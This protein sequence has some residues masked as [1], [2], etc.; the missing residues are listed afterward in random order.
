MAT[1]ATQLARLRTELAALRARANSLET[2]IDDVRA[3]ARALAQGGDREGA[4]TFRAILENLLDEQG[5]VFQQIININAQIE[6]LSQQQNPPPEPPP[7]QSASQQVETQTN[8]APQPLP[9]ANRPVDAADT[10][11]TAPV[12][13]LE[14]TQAITTAS[15]N[16]VAL[17]PPSS[18]ASAEGTAGEAEA[19]AAVLAAGQ[20]AKDDARN[21]AP[22]TAAVN[23]TET[24]EPN[25][26]PRPNILDEFASYTY[27]ASVYLLSTEQYVQLLSSNNKRVDGYNLLF[28]SAG[29]AN[30]RGGPK[31]AGEAS[32]AAPAAADAGRNP[33]FDNDF[34]I[35]SITVETLPLGKGT[36][37]VHNAS[38]LKF[39]LVE[40]NGI[41]LLDRL[42]DA[43][44]NFEPRD[45]TGRVNYTAVTYLMVIR[46]YGYDSMGQAVQVRSRQYDAEGA[47]DPQAVIEKF[48]PFRVNAINWSVGSRLVTY[49]WECTPIGQQIAGYTAR[50]TVP[51]DVQ[52]T[53]TT[54]GKLLSGTTAFSN[55]NAPAANPGASTTA[56]AG[57][58]QERAGTSTPAPTTL[59]APAKAIAAPSDKR[60]LVQGLADALNQFQQ[61]LVKR[62][63]YT[64][65]DVYEIEFAGPGSE[66]IR[67]AVLASA[68]QNPIAQTAAG[69]AATQDP[70][71]LRPATNSVDKTTKN[72]SITAGQQILQVIDL[73]IRNSSYVYDQSLVIVEKD[74]TV[75]P[76]PNARNQSVRWYTITMQAERISKELDPKRNDYAYRIKYVISPFVVKNLDSVYFPRP[77][78][79]GVHKSYPYWFTGQNTAVL[80]YNE[81]LN[82]LY[83]LTISGEVPGNDNAR[84]L[85]DNYT[86]S[87]ADIVK[88][89]Y[90]PRSSE[91]SSGAQGKT[92]ELGANAAESLL[93][94]SDVGEATVKIVGDPDWIQQGSIFRGANKQNFSAQVYNTGFLP[95]GSI[96]FD[97]QDVLFEIV[98]KRPNDYDIFTGKADPYVRSAARYNN[99]SAEQSRV[100][101]CKKVVS[102]FRQG[103]FEQTL[104]GALYLFPKPN[105]TNTA[106]PAAA[107]ESNQNSDA[108]RPDTGSN[109]AGT[110]SAIPTQAA[111]AELSRAQFAQ[112][113][114]RRLDIGDGG[115]AAIEGA[116]ASAA[117][118]KPNPPAININNGSAAQNIT[119]LVD[120]ITAPP[121]RLFS[122]PQPP[123]SGT[124]TSVQSV[125]FRTPNRLPA[126][127]PRVGRLTNTQVQDLVNQQSSAVNNN[128]T[129][130]NNPANQSGVIDA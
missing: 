47:S 34:Y 20:G 11:T 72:F 86:A 108:G 50:G 122:Q 21:T 128:P 55:Q 97:S 94:P 89:S 119:Q 115:V 23:A 59:P 44:A 98:W 117:L 79:S 92:N 84:R 2:E 15:D 130:V 30:N 56:T 126:A 1:T 26:R 75:K 73:V 17:R 31:G 68:G 49:E 70:G 71:G 113:D 100:Y 77:K 105:Q 16:G 57:N 123:T 127:D 65:A 7:A 61:D 99:Y 103:R 18:G 13:P 107:A 48:I 42:Y 120:Q 114:P 54:V 124:G 38:S 121:I 76:N 28:Q 27:S 60:T 91:S 4:A 129:S 112:V 63:I 24:I 78:F 109:L 19:A 53:E 58:D 52:L 10:G 111:A 110:I 12:K 62:N 5:R 81:K 82:A 118:I 22:P 101:H 67:D 9:T 45:A 36:N 41:T 93:S 51:Y 40:P 46:F 116:R 37:A 66:K 95:D 102:E 85:R 125:V 90:A 25:I 104:H 32:A 69:K 33:F 106:N 96:S 87:L 83:H 14:E 29:A 6:R 35:D 74:G 43:V 39:T 64:Y 88:Y 8:Q 80:D 3:R